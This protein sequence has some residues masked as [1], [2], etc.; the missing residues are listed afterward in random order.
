MIYLGEGDK[1]SWWSYNAGMAYRQLAEFYD[2]VFGDGRGWLDAARAR[3]VDPLLPRVT[4]ACDLA[5]GT[6]DTALA[7]AG[8][9]IR[10]YGVD[11]SPGM[12]RASRRKARETG[13]PLRVIQAD[14][15]TFRMPE[16]V[17]LILCEAD[18]INHVPHP[19]DLAKVVRAAARALRPGGHF[20]IDAN[21][22]ACFEKLWPAT[23]W[24]ERPGVVAVMHGGC[25]P[26]G[27][28]AWSDVEWF[29]REGRRWRR[30][31]ERVD[32]V[33]WSAEVFRA[34][35][36]AAGFDRIR[37]WDGA[38]FFPKGGFIKRGYRTFYLARKTPW[39]PAAEVKKHRL[40]ACV[41]Q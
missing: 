30:E 4:V 23:L 5:C 13:V 36:A 15:R 32:E 6:G 18:A 31:H 21:N 9:G 35:L 17:D 27:E 14:M 22:R 12:C 8:R 20:Y 39:Q 1:R 25:H 40:L 3:I 41:A 33:C 16:P 37:T 34:T 19:R 26:S 28:R 10:M 29:I 11:L 7:L 38:Q 24:I 2:C